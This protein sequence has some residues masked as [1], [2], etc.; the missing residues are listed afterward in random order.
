MLRHPKKRVSKEKSTTTPV[1]GFCG[2]ETVTLH[3][4][5][6]RAPAHKRQGTTDWEGSGVVKGN[7]SWELI[8]LRD[9]EVVPRYGRG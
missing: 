1:L 5:P 6:V 8:N 3:F 2:A 7:H 9:G 4:D